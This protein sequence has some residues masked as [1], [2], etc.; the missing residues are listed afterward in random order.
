MKEKRNTAV[1]QDKNRPLYPIP[2]I[3]IMVVPMLPLL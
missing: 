3:G 1:L 2:A